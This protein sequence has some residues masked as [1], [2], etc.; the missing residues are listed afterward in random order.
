MNK[1]SKLTV[2]LLSSVIVGMLGL[3]FAAEPLYSAF[4]RVTGFGGT[5]QVAVEKPKEILERGVRVAFDAN[6]AKNAPL[7]FR[8][9][10][11][12]VDV[13]L[14]ETMMVF[15]EVT[16]MSK[17]PV[18]A[19]A[20]F[21]V[22]PYKIGRYF[23]KLECFCFQEQTYEPGKPVKLPVVFF[24][25]PE[26]AKDWQ[27]DDVRGITLSYT[28]YGVTGDTPAIPLENASAVN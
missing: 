18:R 28:Y 6:V 15:Y 20:S 12:H 19:A 21:N 3:S 26:M 24:V 4:C 27:A 13:K 25:S 8:P 2:I 16:N 10:Q 22:T 7:K 1:R 14:G 5:T 9:L 23:E 17:E 11:A